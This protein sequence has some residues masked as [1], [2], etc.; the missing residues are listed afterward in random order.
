MAERRMFAKTIIDSDAFLDMPLS[1]QAL[2]FHL[3]MR[4]DDEGFINNPKKIQRMVGS[5]EDDL[6]LLTAKRFILAFDSG[7]IV[8]K[9]WKLHNY[10]RSDRFKPTMYL[11][12]K[13]QLITKENKAYSVGMT[14]GIPE[15]DHLD[16]Q[17]RLGKDR[18]GKDS[19]DILSSSDEQDSPPK[20]VSKHKYGEFNNVLLTDEELEKLKK[21]FVDWNDRI[22]KLSIY[23]GSSGKSYKSH[24]LTILSWARKEKKG[25]DQRDTGEYDNLF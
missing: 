14:V 3:S 1:T 17:V 9:H 16:T 11:E 18:L 20:K 21:E 22:D 2:Y 10:I 12:E 5:S 23:I 4:A 19:K 15:A 6:K 25:A 24:Y 7:V 13:S 8:I